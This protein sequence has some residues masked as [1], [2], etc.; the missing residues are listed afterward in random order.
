V[1]SENQR[2]GRRSREVE[3]WKKR[4]YREKEGA[5]KE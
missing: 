5:K 1:R 4:V 2:K 3:A